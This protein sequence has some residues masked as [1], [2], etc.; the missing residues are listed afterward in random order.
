MGGGFNPSSSLIL[1]QSTAN[2]KLTLSNDIDLNGSTTRK[3]SVNANE[4]VLSGTIR[5]TS[6]TPRIE[7]NGGGT[8]VLTGS[9]TYTGQNWLNSGKF[10]IETSDNAGAGG[11]ILF[12]GGT[13]QIR[14]TTLTQLSGLGHAVTFNNNS[15]VGLD[16][17]DKD[18]VFTTDIALTSGSA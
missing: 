9:N 5:S 18:N 11:G 12:R 7:K 14:G 3:I 4:A 13:L 1:N 10:S 6:G 8:L 15:T 2:A 16:I 17:D